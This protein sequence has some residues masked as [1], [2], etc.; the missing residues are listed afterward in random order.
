MKLFGYWRSSSSWRVRIL[1]GYKQLAYEYV[2]VN[3][4]AGA[5]KDPAYQRLNPVGQVPT[6]LLDDGRQLSQ[7]MAIFEWLEETAPSPP[8]LP[9]D[10]YLRARARQLA[11]LINSGI[12]PMQNLSLL[13]TIQS[14]GV[15]EKAWIRGVLT[16]GL[17][18][19]AA[20]AGPT[21]GRFLV[22]DAV[23]VA[24][25]FL[26]PQLYSARR[27]DVDLAAWPLL[28]RVEESCARLPAFAAAHAD[29][30]PDAVPT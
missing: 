29:R 5:Q 22:G 4:L 28:L 1:L 21:A 11:E 15:D 3:L 8:L 25:V 12:Q 7:S 14:F 18:A 30:Q 13:R 16:T 6:L 17:A 19:L 20:S 10:P 27:F 9:A 23:T 2:A 24:D 26:V